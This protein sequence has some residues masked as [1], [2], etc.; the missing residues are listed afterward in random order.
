MYITHD[1]N[2]MRLYTDVTLLNLEY[3]HICTQLQTPAAVGT[4]HNTTQLPMSSIV[5]GRTDAEL[6][7]YIYRVI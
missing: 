2:D 6:E 5:D 7:E 4:K 1:N 3:V